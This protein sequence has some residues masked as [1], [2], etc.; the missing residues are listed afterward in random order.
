[1]TR[2]LTAGLAGDIYRSHRRQGLVGGK[3]E[4]RPGGH[5]NP[6][7]LLPLHLPPSQRTLLLP[8]AKG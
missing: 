4:R 8:P 5:T 6:P 3:Q 2:S 7:S 1:M